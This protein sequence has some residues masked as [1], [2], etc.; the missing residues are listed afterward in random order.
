MQRVDSERFEA[1]AHSFFTRQ[2]SDISKVFE[3][4]SPGPEDPAS[5]HNEQA[6]NRVIA[7]GYSKLLSFLDENN[8]SRVVHQFHGQLRDAIEAE[9]HP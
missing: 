5:A 1:Q 7:L 4:F 9:M 6:R 3:C 8:I 2:W